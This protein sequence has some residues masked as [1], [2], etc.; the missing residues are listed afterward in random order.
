MDLA[1]IT[2]VSVGAL[3]GV[4]IVVDWRRRRARAVDARATAAAM[5]EV[6]ATRDEARG[7]ALGTSM[8]GHGSGGGLV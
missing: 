3:L 1:L 2:A 7:L 4:S 6:E 5:R 8:I